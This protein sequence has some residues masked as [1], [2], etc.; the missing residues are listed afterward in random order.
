MF[1]RCLNLCFVVYLKHYLKPKG[2][3]M[4]KQNKK[5]NINQLS[6]NF[7]FLQEENQDL[8]SQKPVII[9]VEQ[10]FHIIRAVK[11]VGF[12]TAH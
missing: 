11:P 10:D 4:S 5:N 9:A 2:V 1:F 6:P 8:A 7:S 12:F 3:Y